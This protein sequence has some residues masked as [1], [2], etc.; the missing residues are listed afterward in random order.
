M[1]DKGYTAADRLVANGGSASGV[2]PAAAAVERPD[3]FAA[4]L[5]DF[6]FLDMLRYHHFTAIKGWTRGYGS[7][8]DPKE[9]AVLRSYSPLHNLEPGKCY[10]ATLT[11]VGEEDTSTSPMHGYKFTAALQRAQGCGRAAMLKHI[12]GAGHYAYGTTAEQAA[13]T[14]AEMLA[15]LV[16]TLGLEEDLRRAVVG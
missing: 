3:L 4:S 8:E 10:P 9:F 11:V 5:I 14:E 7:S 12:P 1:I 15:F 13:R 6:P 2:V 16:R